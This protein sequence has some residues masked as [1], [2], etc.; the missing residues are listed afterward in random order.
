[1]KTLIKILIMFVIITLLPREIFSQKKTT[2]K[3]TFYPVWKDKNW[4]FMNN[5]GVVV[6]PIIFEDVDKYAY[7]NTFADNLIPVKVD[8]KWGY[9]NKKGELVIKAKYSKTEPFKDGIAKVSFAENSFSLFDDKVGTYINKSEEIVFRGDK[10]KGTGLLGTSYFSEGF[11]C[12]KN[13]ENQYGFINN[14]GVEIITCQ[15]SSADSFSEGLA[16]VK[17]GNYYGFI[18]KTGK[19]VIEPIFIEANKFSDGVAI[20]TNENN[21]IVFID[22][23]GKVVGKTKETLK[24]GFLELDKGFNQGLLAIEKEGKIGYI[25]KTGKIVIQ[26]KYDDSFGMVDGLIAVCLNGNKIDGY[27]GGSWEDGWGFIDKTGKTV[28]PNKYSKVMSFAEGLCS[29]KDKDSGKW[30]IID[31]T[32]KWIMKPQFDDYPE[33]SKNGVIKVK[34]KKYYNGEFGYID[35]TGKWL[36]V[37]PKID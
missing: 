8:G 22:K 19:M 23:K 12:V 3:E 25:D 6:V 33:S 14:K 11:M 27:F 37:M 1:M 20:C 32:G 21:E 17:K 18:D 34:G 13:E 36:W 30:G 2:Q 5:K 4:G 29:V 15:Y 7:E 24:K 9:C 26:P 31:K 28:I 35:K 16:K 10:Y